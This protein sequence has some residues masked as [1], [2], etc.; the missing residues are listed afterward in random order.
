MFNYLNF[1]LGKQYF[2][3]SNLPTVP[4][5]F[6]SGVVMNDMMTYL[7]FLDLLISTQFFLP[8]RLWLFI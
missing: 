8:S 7:A 2:L 6:D 1:V 4:F 3:L 5:L